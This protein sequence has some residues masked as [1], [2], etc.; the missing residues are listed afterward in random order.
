MLSIG[1]RFPDFSITALVPA[2]WAT[3]RRPPRPTFSP[4]S[5]VGSS[6]G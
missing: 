3:Y 2:G 4:P 1:D 5:P 6:P